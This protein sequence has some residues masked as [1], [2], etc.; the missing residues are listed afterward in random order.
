MKEFIE[1]MIEVFK[2]IIYSFKWLFK[3]EPDIKKKTI[4]QA[5]LLVGSILGIIIKVALSN[6]GV[7]EKIKEKPKRWREPK[8]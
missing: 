8:E 5:G 4:F 7:S 3:I 1:G 6:N 2:L